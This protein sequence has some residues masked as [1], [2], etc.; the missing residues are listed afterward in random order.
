MIL[1]IGNRRELCGAVKENHFLGHCRH[2]STLPYL[3]LLLLHPV[4]NPRNFL[5][6]RKE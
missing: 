4:S 1:A 5:V 3:L 2:F 6:A